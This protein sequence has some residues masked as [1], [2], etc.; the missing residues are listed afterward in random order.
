MARITEKGLP[1]VVY[2]LRATSSATAMKRAELEY[3]KNIRGGKELKREKP[4]MWITCK[5]W[6]PTEA[7]KKSF[8]GVIL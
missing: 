8:E 7:E 4:P 3:I 6:R 1:P 5:V 2:M